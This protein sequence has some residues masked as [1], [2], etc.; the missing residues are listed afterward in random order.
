MGLL[1]FLV[2]INNTGLG[3]EPGV[4]AQGQGQHRGLGDAGNGRAAGKVLFVFLSLS[5]SSKEPE[6][7]LLEGG[8][9][10]AG[11]QTGPGEPAGRSFGASLEPLPKTGLSVS[12]VEGWGLW[13]P[14]R[15][16]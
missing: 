3:S 10:G 7:L 2:E 13:H 16:P 11:G 6:Q 8:E 9:M 12:L 4:P 1:F 5:L 14:L 15:V